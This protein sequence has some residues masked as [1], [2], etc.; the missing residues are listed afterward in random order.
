MLLMKWL[1][2]TEDG[3]VEV[4]AFDR[5]TSF[6]VAP[7]GARLLDSRLLSESG[8]DL[9][10]QVPEP[11]EPRLRNGVHPVSYRRMTVAERSHLR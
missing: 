5:E 2:Q 7:E 1:Y 8:W 6:S 9:D 11:P 4:K 3:L 10:F